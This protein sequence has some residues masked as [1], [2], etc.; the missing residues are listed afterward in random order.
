MCW[1][2]KKTGRQ[3]SIIPSQ[4]MKHCKNNMD[5]LFQKKTVT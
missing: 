2:S 4:E 3:I 1:K 5:Y